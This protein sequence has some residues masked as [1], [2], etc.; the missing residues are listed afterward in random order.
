M[1]RK[2]LV[3]LSR[4]VN[5]WAEKR[6]VPFCCHAYDT[7]DDFGALGSVRGTD[8]RETEKRGTTIVGQFCR[9][10]WVSDGCHQLSAGDGLL[11][12]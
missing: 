1:E 2:Q 3:L 11:M 9:L 12:L 7:I 4:E 10:W 5:D 6:S 8:I